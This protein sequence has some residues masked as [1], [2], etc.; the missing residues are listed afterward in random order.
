[1]LSECLCLLIGSSNRTRDL[2]RELAGWAEFPGPEAA[3]IGVVKYGGR[4]KM[5]G[6]EVAEVIAA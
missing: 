3:G 1:M 4:T 5:L 2:V 6:T